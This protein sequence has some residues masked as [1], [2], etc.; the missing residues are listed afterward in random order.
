MA[1]VRDGQVVLERGYGLADVENEVTATADTVY[2]LAS[3]S[4]M[5]TG[6]AVMQLVEQGKIDLAAPIQT[7]VPDFPE[8]QAPITCEHSAQASKRHSPLQGR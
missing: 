4:K 5:L 2:R 8:K 7:Y 3:I 1:L 6:V